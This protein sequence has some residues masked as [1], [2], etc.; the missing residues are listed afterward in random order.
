MLVDHLYAVVKDLKVNFNPEEVSAVRWVN[1]AELELEL[2]ERAELYSPWFK[3]VARDYILPLVWNQ[4]QKPTA[5]KPP[6]QIM[7]YPEPLQ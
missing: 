4:I 3:A 5:L 6:S 1:P 7:R 2:R